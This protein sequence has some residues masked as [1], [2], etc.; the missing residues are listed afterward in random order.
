MARRAWALCLIGAALA[1]AAPAA[2]ARKPAWRSYRDSVAR[3]HTPTPGKSAPV[4]D[5]G[6]PL[7]ALANLN[8]SETLELPAA[9]DDGD[10]S[11]VSLE[12]AGR[13]FRDT[14]TG[15]THPMEPATLDL[16]YRAQ[17]RFNAHE[18]R[19]VS[20]YRAGKNPRARTSPHG[21]GRAVDLVVPGAADKDVAAWAR[22]QGFVG[23]GVYPNAG[24]CHLDTRPSSYFWVDPSG[25]GQRNRDIPLDK[26]QAQQSDAEARQRRQ[27]R[28]LPYAPPAPQIEAAWKGAVVVDEHEPVGEGEHD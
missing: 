21:Q 23:V 4:D 1:L 5:S 20:G 8:T 27:P 19:V 17:R 14:R 2:G 6:R 22:S 24:Y 16:I 13:F 3:W 28:V 25:P 11:A 9:S 7:L 10:F 15:Q 12:R 18:I 26:K